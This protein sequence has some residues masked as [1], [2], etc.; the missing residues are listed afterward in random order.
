[1]F[2]IGMRTFEK[3]YIFKKQYETKLHKYNYYI[4]AVQI[5]RGQS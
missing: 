2:L 3:I 1:M 5:L 4:Y